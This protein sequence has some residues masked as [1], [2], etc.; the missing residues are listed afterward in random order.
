MR[1]RWRPLV[2]G[3]A[4]AAA[5]FVLAQAQIF[6]PSAPAAGAASG[7]DVHNGEILFEGTCAGCHGPGGEG[8]GIGPR[9]EGSGLDAAAVTAAVREG[10]GVMPAGLVSGKDEADV[11]AYVVKISS[12]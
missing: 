3:A 11:V 12:P 5:T 7:G 8:G 2:V 1:R 10:R 9:L 4:V 6:E